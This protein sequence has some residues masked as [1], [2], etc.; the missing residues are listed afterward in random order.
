MGAFADTER[1]DPPLRSIPIVLK[2]RA[3]IDHEKHL[4]PAV[5]TR[6]AVLPLRSAFKIRPNHHRQPPSRPVLAP[7]S[8]S[9]P[10]T[11]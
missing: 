6:L 4:I 5:A 10:A 7:W 1:I 9:S 11:V 8:K 3:I 2:Q